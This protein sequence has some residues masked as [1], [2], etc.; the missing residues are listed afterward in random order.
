V[1]FCDGE[2]ALLRVSSVINRSLALQRYIE[3]AW[4]TSVHNN[5]TINDIR[6]TR[7]F[8][9][10]INHELTISEYSGTAEIIGLCFL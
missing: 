7:V 4:A 8:Y 2:F 6:F 3:C 10:R 5:T 9:R 1:P